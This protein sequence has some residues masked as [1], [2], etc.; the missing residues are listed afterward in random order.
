[1][2]IGSHCITAWSKTQSSI[3]TSSAESD[4]YGVVRSAY[5]TLG[6]FMFASDLGRE[7]RPGIDQFGPDEFH[8]QERPGGPYLREGR[9][10]CGLQGWRGRSF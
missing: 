1:M 9:G 10:A 7:R 4:V 8:L 6:F 3:T 5:K 2:L